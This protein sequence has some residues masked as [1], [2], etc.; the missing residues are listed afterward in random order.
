M[1]DDRLKEAFKKVKEDMML[2]T[3]EIEGVKSETRGVKRETSDF[4][5]KK[6][7]NFVK[8][9]ENELNSM[10][11][12]IREFDDKLKHLSL[13][14]GKTLEEQKIMQNDKTSKIDMNS[15]DERFQELSEILG[16]KISL[17][18]ASIRMEF[19]EEI[20]K[21]YDKVFN[22]ILDL[23]K[24][25]SK[26][27]KKNDIKD[28]KTENKVSK[29]EIVKEEPKVSKKSATKSEKKNENVDELYP[30]RKEGKIKKIAKWLF[31]DEEE[32]E[33]D[34]IKEQIKGKSNNKKKDDLY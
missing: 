2:L 13:Q 19:T 14:V 21:I 6:F 30:E 27:E 11:L 34:D 28:L 12:Y 29:K 18:T 10:N 17:E 16:E 33:M 1:R 24:D 32:E 7:D 31:V 25:L 23:K 26:I 20:A 4:D 3:K 15:I 8:N 22:E 9:V 5:K